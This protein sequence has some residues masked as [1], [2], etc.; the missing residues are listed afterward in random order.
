VLLDEERESQIMVCVSR[1]RS[2]QLVLDL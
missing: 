1:A 2:G